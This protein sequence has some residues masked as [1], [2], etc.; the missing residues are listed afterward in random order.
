M[1]SANI[2]SMKKGH[3]G[4]KHDK[5]SKVYRGFEDCESV[6]SVNFN[7]ENE[8]MHQIQGE[9]VDTVDLSFLEK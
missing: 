3:L 8:Q 9:S 4:G 5:T 6:D 7:P 1:H 2:E